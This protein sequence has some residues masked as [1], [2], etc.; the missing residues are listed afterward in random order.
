M[1][2][3]EFDKKWG[4]IS[5][6]N[7]TDD[8]FVEFKEDCFSFYET[9]G[10]S[11]FFHSPYDEYGEHNGKPFKV[12]RRATTDECDLDAMPLWVVTFEGEEEPYY[13]YPEEIC[14]E[15]GK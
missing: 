13:C 5:T 4:G 7:M 8:E 11:D 6:D 14:R 9:T 2:Q 1:T 12:V 10:F 15:E 3:A